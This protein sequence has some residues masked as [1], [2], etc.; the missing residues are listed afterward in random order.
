LAG[1]DNT[2]NSAD[3]VFLVAGGFQA[4]SAQ[5]A[6]RSKQIGSVG[7]TTADGLV[8]I[9]F[10]DPQ[11]KVF[12]QVGNVQ[13]ASPRINDPFV[14]N[15]GTYNDFT[16]DGV[17]GMGNVALVFLGNTD[18]ACPVT[19]LFDE[20]FVANYT[21]FGPAQ[22]LQFFAVED[23]QNGSHVEGIE[24]PPDFVVG[25]CA[26]NPV[27]L[28]RRMVTLPGVDDLETWIFALSGVY[29]Y[30]TPTGC[31][32]DYGDNPTILAGCV[33]DPFFS[34]QATQL[35][36][37]PR[38]LT[39]SRS[40]TNPTGV[41]GTW[42]TLDGFIPTTDLTQY[43]NTATARWGQAA[44]INRVFGTNIQQAGQDGIMNS[45]DDRILLAGGGTDYQSFGGEP[46][47]PS[48]EI[49]LPPNVN[50]NVPSP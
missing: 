11:T 38:D 18:A 10:F 3:D 39:S 34:L 45:A 26:T 12:T 17:R 6:P 4:L 40:R 15:L 48:A 7:R 30:I 14:V 32:Y 47:T 5:F 13:L 35:G 28:P 16:P 24:Y 2:L 20:L 29:I 50:S 23:T 19:P 25:R 43:A 41:V 49:F 31:A 36:L 8:V 46:T 44:G 27:V 9:E 22:G 37:S 33:F 42:L 21:G 1:P